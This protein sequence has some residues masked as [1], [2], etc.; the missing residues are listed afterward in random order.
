M[1][2]VV[3]KVTPDQVRASAEKWFGPIPKAAEPPRPAAQEQEPAQ[4]SQRK[5]VVEP[6]QIGQ[7]TS[8][9]PIW[10]GSTTSRR[11]LVCGGSCAS[12]AGRGGS[13]AFAI[14][15]NHF[16]ALRLHLLERRLADDDEHR[17]V[18]LVVRVVELLEICRASSRRDP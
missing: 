7:P 10:L 11:F 4:T 15:P 1:L 17:V 9:R 3:G 6:G 14:G 5:Q 16:S 12:F 8:V 18:R 2:V 13:A